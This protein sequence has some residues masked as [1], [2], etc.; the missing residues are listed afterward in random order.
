MKNCL[1]FVTDKNYV[2]HFKSLIM[3]VKNI[4][5]WSEDICVIF[6]NIDD[7]N[8]ISDFENKGILPF[9]VK[10]ENPYYAKFSI[11]KKFFKKWDNIM[12]MDAD[13]VIN[14]DIN[15]LIK[16]IND[17]NKFLCDFEGIKLNL[18][19]K[20]NENYEKLEQKYGINNI[21]VFNS[22]C[23]VFNT[24]LLT[25]TTFDE[26]INISI[27]MESINKHGTPEYGGDQPIINIFFKDFAKQIKFLSFHLKPKGGEVALH[28]CRWGAP[29]KEK[30]YI[31]QYT[32]YLNMW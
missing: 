32:K 2:N 23:L 13:F 26:I 24:N 7:K 16:Q 15:N 31:N 22:G 20:Q 19:L 10:F 30:R 21:N 17:E 29:W 3:Q 14:G 9:E 11:F 27:D 4:G 28:T 18:C 1:V 6:N 8:I 12:Y 5:K 25:D